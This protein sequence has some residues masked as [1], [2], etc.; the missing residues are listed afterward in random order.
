LQIEVAIAPVKH[1]TTRVA[2]A[3]PPKKSVPIN[4]RTQKVTVAQA[5]VPKKPG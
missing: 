4:R 1:T 5:K 2:T 3:S